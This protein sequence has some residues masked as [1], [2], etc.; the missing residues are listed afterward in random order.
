MHDELGITKNI[1]IHHLPPRLHGSLSQTLCCAEPSIVNTNIHL[2][3]FWVGLNP[4]EHFSKFQILFINHK[5]VTFST[6]L[7]SVSLLM[8]HLREISY[9]YKKKEEIYEMFH[10]P[11]P[12]PPEDSM[13]AQQSFPPSSHTQPLELQPSPSLGILGN[14]LCLVRFSVSLFPITCS[15]S[16][17]NTS[18]ILICI[19]SAHVIFPFQI[20]VVLYKLNQN[21]RMFYF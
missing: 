17:S 6:C 8:S 10:Q 20:N 7:I 9:K 11:F 5:S 18:T 4:G 1:Y 13:P 16:S 15:N 19:Q 3:Q 2:P 12:S 21:I 14:A